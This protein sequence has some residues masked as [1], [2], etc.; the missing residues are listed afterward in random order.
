MSFQDLERDELYRTAIEDFAVEVHHRA[1]KD[2]II[3]ALEK[4]GVTWDLYAKANPAAAGLGEPEATET[5]EEE[6]VDSAGAEDLFVSEPTSTERHA[7][8]PNVVTSAAVT[9]KA[10]PVVRTKKEEINVAANDVWLVHMDR[11]NP[12]FEFRGESK[13]HK[14]TQENPFAVMSAADANAITSTE[15]GFSIATPAQAQAFYERA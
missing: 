13:L 7:N 3:A 15:E 1:G 10:A 9:G 12:Y 5:F 4:D 2:T 8:N 6:P 14:F 11:E